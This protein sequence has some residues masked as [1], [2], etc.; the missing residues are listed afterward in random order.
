MVSVWGRTKNVFFD[1]F[2]WCSLVE[3]TPYVPRRS[4]WQQFSPPRKNCHGVPLAGIGAPLRA[5]VKSWQF[6]RGGE[7]CEH[8][9]TKP[10]KYFSS[11]T[12]NR[13]YSTSFV[14]TKAPEV[15]NGRVDRFFEKKNQNTKNDNTERRTGETLPHTSGTAV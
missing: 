9:K 3:S 8:H 4:P 2:L 1:V 11:P 12:S 13:L 7:N 5:R 6:L 14:K 10:T 15:R